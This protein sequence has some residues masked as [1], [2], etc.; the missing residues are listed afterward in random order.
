[1]A[2]C[3]PLLTEPSPSHW[4][5]NLQAIKLLDSVI[6]QAVSAK[7]A[8]TDPEQGLGRV[9]KQAAGRALVTATVTDQQQP[10][11][12]AIKVSETVVWQAL[13]PAAVPSQSPP[14]QAAIKAVMTVAALAVAAAA[15]VQSDAGAVLV[16]HQTSVVMA[17]MMT[18]IHRGKTD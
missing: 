15:I 7:Q 13:L 5:P 16:T 1:M 2:A 4:L 18:T 14:A 9:L 3:L 8:V 12:A 17:A 6:L 11:T 10:A